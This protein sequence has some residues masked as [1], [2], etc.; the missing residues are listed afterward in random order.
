LAGLLLPS[1]LDVG[2]HIHDIEILEIMFRTSSS[3]ASMY[4]ASQ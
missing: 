2:I 3:V 4:S 1:G